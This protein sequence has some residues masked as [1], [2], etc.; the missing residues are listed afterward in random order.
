MKFNNFFLLLLILFLLIII[1]TINLSFKRNKEKIENTKSNNEI[2]DFII[3]NSSEYKFIKKYNKALY[4]DISND[5]LKFKNLI[6]IIHY[7]P[8]LFYY[9]YYAF[10]TLLDSIAYNI[11]ALYLNIPQ[12][13][14]LK[15]L[16]KTIKSNVI[17]NLRK[18]LLELKKDCDYITSNNIYDKSVLD[19]SLKPNNI[20]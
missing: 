7:K 17:N 18:E 1:L 2:L 19:F 6:N 4:Q 9:Y 8:S 14:K 10:E 20:L 12:D 11:D 13:E 15:N 16:I 3:T 5:V